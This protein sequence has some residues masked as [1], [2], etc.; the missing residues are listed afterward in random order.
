MVTEIEIEG[1]IISR[2]YIKDLIVV[3]RLNDQRCGLAFRVTDNVPVEAGG[4]DG[5]RGTAG[6]QNAENDQIPSTSIGSLARR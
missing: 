6:E 2:H 1:A 3:M 4:V 5:T